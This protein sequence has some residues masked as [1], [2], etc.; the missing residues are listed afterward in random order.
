MRTADKIFIPLLGIF[1]LINLSATVFKFID[2]KDC[3]CK[4]KED[5]KE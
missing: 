1:T 3:D 5:E 2:L 4:A